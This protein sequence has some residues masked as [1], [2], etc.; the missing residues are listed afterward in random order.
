MSSVRSFM[1][2]HFLHFNSGETV[3]AARA[4]EAHLEA[5]GKMMVTLAGAMSTGRIG[6]LLSQMIRAD[7]VHAITCTG[8]NLE[9]DLMYLLAAGTYEYLP[10][11]RSLRTEDEVA[12]YE[13]GMN[14]VTD[15]AIPED[16]MRHLEERLLVQWQQASEQGVS[17]RPAEHL[18]DVLGQADLEQHFQAP[19]QSSWVLTAREHQIPIWTPGWEDSTTGNMF[20]AY[21]WRGVL[22]DH[23]CVDTGTAQ[24]V[25]LMRWYHDRHGGADDPSLGFFQIGGG[26]AGDFPICA[27]PCLIQDLQIEVP[28]WG[29]FCQISDAVT[30]YGGYSGAPPNEKITWGKLDAESPRFMIQ[31]DAS[32]V[33][34]LIFGYLLGE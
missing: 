30:S 2:S 16:V 11:W 9:E 3:R 29:Y 24:M 15:V 27:V 22:P 13:R 1:D 8:A 19:A 25:S 6:T 32:I 5:G 31:S 26:I 10:E 23:R 12:L 18:W 33:A 34:P 14:R 7:K 21:V 28:K 20:A 17:K 4:Y